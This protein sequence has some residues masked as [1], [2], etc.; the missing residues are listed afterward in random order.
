[1]KSILYSFLPFFLASAA[2]AHESTHMHHH[3]SD[4]NWMPLAA[5]LLVIGAAALIAWS[6]R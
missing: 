1:M 4:P 2:A 6:R 5:G 3:L